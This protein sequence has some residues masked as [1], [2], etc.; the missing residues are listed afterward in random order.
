MRSGRTRARGGVLSRPF[1]A[2]F[3]DYD[4][5]FYKIEP[6][7][8]APAVALVTHVASGRTFRGGSLNDELLALSFGA[9]RLAP[10]TCRCALR[11]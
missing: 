4:Y 5:D 1:A 9:Q 2:I 11:S 8:F 6:M 7:L 3:K 10:A